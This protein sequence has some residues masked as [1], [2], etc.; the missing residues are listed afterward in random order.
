MAGCI[1]ELLRAKGDLLV[2]RKTPGVDVAE[3]CFREAIEQG[4][5]H[6]ALAWELRA[7]TS[8]ARLLRG[9]GLG[10]EATQVLQ[11]VYDRYSEGFE[12]VDV[13]SARA[14][15]EGLR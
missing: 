2:H 13:T 3:R 7:A 9:R 8:L 15:L 1:P 11:P 6:G 12:T 5:R 4:R 14:L 10:I